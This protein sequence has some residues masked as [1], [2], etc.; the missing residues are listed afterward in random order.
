MECFTCQLVI[1]TNVKHELVNVERNETHMKNS[2]EN[3]KHPNSSVVVKA[4]L[5]LSY[6]SGDR[7][8]SKSKWIVM[9]DKTL[10]R[11][12]NLN[13]RL[14]IKDGTAKFHGTVELIP[15]I[16]N[17]LV[18][19]RIA[20]QRYQQYHEKKASSLRDCLLYTSRCV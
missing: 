13:T 2:N 8:F 9:E 19:A 10:M 12:K 16:K 3:L 20:R 4:T 7:Q 11:L 1:L 17:L 18:A 6:K 15:N 5:T 14:Y